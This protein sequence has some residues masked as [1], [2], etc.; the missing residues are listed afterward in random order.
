MKTNQIMIRENLVEQR[1][2]DSYFN[3]NITVNNWNLNNP[4]SSKKLADFKIL[5]STKDFIEHLKNNES[6]ESP[7]VSGK[8][9]TWMHPLLY[10][11]FCM[12]ISLEFKTMALKFVLDGLIKTRHSAGDFYNEM[13]AAIMERHIEVY[14]C[15]PTPMVY[16]QEALLINNIAGVSKTQRNEMTESQ[17]EK[18]TILQ[19]V[20]TNLIKKGVGKVARKNQLDIIS[21]SL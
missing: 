20:N 19:K 16:I 4:S 3:A 14:N 8:T 18:I 6:I 11:D 5:K 13:A 12:W 1:T 15:K 17:L 7:I 10:I 9:G 2:S 21:E